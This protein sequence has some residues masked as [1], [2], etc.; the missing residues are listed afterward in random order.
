MYVALA[1]ISKYM[2]PETILR[3]A[4]KMYGL[5]PQEALEMAY[6][7]MLSEARNGLRTVRKPFAVA[8]PESAKEGE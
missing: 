2:K 8:P 1:R 4:E 7:H 5:E 6:E 3:K